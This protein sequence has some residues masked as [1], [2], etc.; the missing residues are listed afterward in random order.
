[1]SDFVPISVQVA[2]MKQDWPMLKARKIDRARQA[3]RWVG[4]VKPHLTAY[5]LE[6]RYAEGWPEVRV[7]SPAL[8]QLPGNPEGRLPHIYGPVDD[9]TLCLFD[10]QAGEWRPSMLLSRTIVPWSFDWLAC[11]EL[12][13]MTGEWTG[14]GRHPAPTPVTNEEPAP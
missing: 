2:A 1:M 3:A 9:P 4:P 10:P 11:Y 5:A 14:G 6:I 12:W 7:L 13:L 8:K